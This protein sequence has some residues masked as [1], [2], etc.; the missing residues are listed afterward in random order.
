MRFRKGSIMAVT[1]DDHVEDGDAPISFVV[2]G[3]ISKVAKTHI[4][5]DS[6]VYADSNEKHDSNEKRFTILRKVITRA[7]KLE[8][9]A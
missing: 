6:W 9:V 8:V 7:K 4:C 3:R 1:F 5:I 2:F